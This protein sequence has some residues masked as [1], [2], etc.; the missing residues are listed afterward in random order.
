MI[1]DT[2]AHVARV[3]PDPVVQYLDRT[4]TADG[5]SPTALTLGKLIVVLWTMLFAGVLPFPQMPAGLAM[6][7]PGAPEAAAV[8]AGLAGAAE[9]LLMWGVMMAAMMYPAVFARSVDYVESVDG[10]AV[11]KLVVG[12]GFLGA[13]SL[14]WAA[15]GV[16]PLAVEA[17]VDINALATTA[18]RFAVPAVLFVAGA[19]QFTR[20]KRGAVATCC[21]MTPSGGD[22]G[23]RLAN[24]LRDGL[25]HFRSCFTCTWA[26]C[27]L[28]V[29][30]GTMNAFWMLLLSAVFTAERAGD[31]NRVAAT[32]GLMLLWSAASVLLTGVP[33]YV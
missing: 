13:Y 7:D 16:I 8:A 24:A 6:T 22:G 21:A 31:G 14:A 28:M 30:F 11:T 9:Y 26:L 3:L 12:T 25:S 17:V 19:Y 15:T 33:G 4:T 10:S 5:L 20:L 23:G 18:G 32:V 1:H 27:G 2:V 29:V